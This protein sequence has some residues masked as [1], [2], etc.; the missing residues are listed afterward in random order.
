MLV[1]LMLPLKSPP[2]LNSTILQRTPFS[3][4]LE[5]DICCLHGLP[6]VWAYS[7]ITRENRNVCASVFGSTLERKSGGLQRR[8][9]RWRFCGYNYNPRY[10]FACC[11]NRRDGNGTR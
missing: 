2:F 6:T 4:E 9:W 5:R 3:I 7:K 11:T 10:L 1:F 8:R